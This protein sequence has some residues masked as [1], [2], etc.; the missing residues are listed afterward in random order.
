MKTSL[1]HIAWSV[2]VSVASMAIRLLCLPPKNNDVSSIVTS[3][4]KVIKS[5]Q[6]YEKIVQAITVDAFDSIKSYYVWV[7]NKR[8]GVKKAQALTRCHHNSNETA[9]YSSLYSVLD[10][11]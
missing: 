5:C 4:N 11:R 8:K 2:Q 6:K 3:I 7:F 9:H 10:G 1:E